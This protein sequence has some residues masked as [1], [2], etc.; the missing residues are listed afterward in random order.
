MINRIVEIK[1]PII[2]TLAVLGSSELNCLCTENWI[3]LENARDILKIFYEVTTDISAE[4]YVMLSKE[5]IFIKILYKFILNYININTLPKEINSMA[6]MIKSVLFSRFGEIEENMLVSQATLL[7]P[8]FKKFAFSNENNCHAAVSFLKANAQ[9]III[10]P[11][12]PISKHTATTSS[13]T[14]N[15]SSAMWKV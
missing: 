14:I 4:K 3:I 5:I 2:A 12:E 11:E 10:E 7:D 13:S 9:S 6:M 15:S 8:R 1:E